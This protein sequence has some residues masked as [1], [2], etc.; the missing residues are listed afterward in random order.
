M[1]PAALDR[2]VLSDGLAQIA[3]FRGTYDSKTDQTAQTDQ[4]IGI[5]EQFGAPPGSEPTSRHSKLT[6]ETAQHPPSC[7]EG[8]GAPPDSTHARPSDGAPEP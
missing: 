3:Q 8:V 4:R 6:S 1:N 2:A 7:A 5:A